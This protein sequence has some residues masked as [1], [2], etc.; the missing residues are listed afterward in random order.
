MSNS[1]QLYTNIAVAQSSFSFPFSYL[2]AVDITA[3]VDGVVVFQNNASTGT[4]V[5]GNTYVVAF[6]APNSTTLTFSP[7]VVA[8]SDVRIQRN[9]NLVTKAV[10]FADGAV[11][12]ELSLDTAIDQVFFGAQEAVDRANESIAVDLDDKWDANNKPI[13]NVANPTNAQDVATK[14]YLENTWLT[15]A[16]KAQLNAL[17][18]PNLNTVANDV[19]NVNT[20]ATNIAD[21]N[22]VATNIAD[23]NTVAGISGNVT[24]AAGISADITA[25]AADATDIGTVSTNIAN[26]NTVAGISADVTTVAA[27]GTDIGVV[28]GISSDVTTVSGISANV[29]TVAGNTSNINAVAADATDIGTVATNI[30]NVNTAAGISANITTVA[31]IAADVTAAATNAS[32]ISAIAAEV[33]KVVTVAN[34]LNEAT[35]EIDVVA[36]NIANVNLV[37]TDIANVNT[38]ATNLTDI[39]AFADTYFI[40]ATAPVSP[41]TGDLWFD[42]TANTMK[43]Y[44]GS[45][46]VNAGSSVNG[47]S[48]RY[49]YTATSGQTSFSATYD[50]GYV[51]V[52]LNGVKLVSGTDFTATDGSTVVL[53][54]GAALNDTVD[55]IGYGTF[56]VSSAVTLPDGVKAS[57]GAG[58]DLQIYHDGSHSYIQDAGQGRL[59][60]RASDG[61]K[62][63]NTDSSK[64]GLSVFPDS[65]VYAYYNNALKFETTATG[66]DVTGDLEADG[67]NI[68]TSS[69]VGS[70]TI[71]EDTTDLASFAVPAQSNSLRIRHTSGGNMRFGMTTS[72]ALSLMTN[73]ADRLTVDAN[74]NVGIG[75]S[76]PSSFNGGANNL[77]V[78]SGSGSEGITIYADNASNSAVFFA[79]TDS[80]TTGQL[81]YQH[82]SNA[83]TFHTN[84]GTERMRIDSSGKLHVNQTSD[85]TAAN[86]SSSA[87]NAPAISA[88]TNQTN[89]TCLVTRHDGGGVAYNV[90]F[91]NSTNFVGSI[92]TTASA[93]SYVTSSDYRL[94]TA[95]NYDWDATTRLKQLRPARFEWIADGDD[96]VPVDGFLA[97][98]VQDVVP[99][100]ITGTKDAMRDEEY[101]VSAATGDIYTPAIEAVLDEDGNEVT[102]AVAEVIHSND[103]E[104][105]EELAEGQLW[106]ETTPAV[107]G[108][109][110]VPDY[111]GID[112]SKLVPLLV[113]TIQELEARITALENV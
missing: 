19:A 12:T 80:T 77:V 34:D 72:H 22:T 20:V 104:R 32:D 5:G 88:R 40:S 14:D 68:G 85:W 98:E 96:A 38:V 45:G 108:T 57:F 110:S 27:D 66:V 43:V 33:A 92:Q 23:V 37:G 29:T 63:D 113:K 84:G 13:K 56:S 41:T 67:I 86:L 3:Y 89:G 11:L 48:A 50:A 52:Y 49:S 100:A 26:V 70:L 4:A 46:F 28:A 39:N 54:T 90:Q 31:G 97:H 87:T 21:V 79:D 30:A 18:I 73:A 95:V 58:S 47:T 94:K 55:I 105:P 83:M 82:A 17:N 101:Q 111:Q 44:D 76:S 15:P 1:V 65:A 74:G 69:S 102:P 10:D 99:E 78:G 8:G 6:S 42:T 7:A 25:V 106:R 61:I 75:T 36:N 71:S 91:Y 60:V 103:V 93:T 16:D 53:A 64:T 107:M 51:D 59:Y 9:T 112:Q 81:N 2:E 24:T 109:R 35:S 62:F